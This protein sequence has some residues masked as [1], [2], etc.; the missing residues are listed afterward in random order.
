M[1]LSNISCPDCG[2]Q[3]DV[4]CGHGPDTPILRA[5]L[6]AVTKE[7]DLYRDAILEAQWS[8][9]WRGSAICPWCSAESGERHSTG[10]VVRA[11]ETHRV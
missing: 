11:A 8:G 4:E 5:Q 6:A 3:F 9:E 1:S 7:R 2:W 10:C